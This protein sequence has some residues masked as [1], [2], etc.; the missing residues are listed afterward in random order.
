MQEGQENENWIPKIIKIFSTP[1]QNS[2]SAM[3]V[4]E[5]T[6]SKR[7]GINL[8]PCVKEHENVTVQILFTLLAESANPAPSGND[9]IVNEPQPGT[10]SSSVSQYSGDLFERTSKVK[11]SVDYSGNR[12]QDAKT[13]KSCLPQ[14][15]GLIKSILN[16]LKKA[17]QDQALNESMRT[18][19]E[20]S[21]PS[22]LK[23]VISN[24]DYYGPNLFLLA[25]DVVTVYI[26]QEPSLLSTLQDNYLTDVVLQAMLVKEVNFSI[27]LY[28]KP[29]VNFIFIEF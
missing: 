9:T 12:W 10:S 21:L 15:A 27:N 8:K 23:H 24:S 20:G 2:E 14:R 6:M 11:E 7:K 3:E 5:E 1:E 29:L 18:V 13:G 26:F 22:S 28:I 25:T 4:D 17:I 19:M 16:F